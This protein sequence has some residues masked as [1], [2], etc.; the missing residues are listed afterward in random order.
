MPRSLQE[1]LAAAGEHNAAMGRGSR[2]GVSEDAMPEEPATKEGVAAGTGEDAGYLTKEETA[3]LPTN[4]R[5]TQIASEIQSVYGDEDSGAGVKKKR[6]RR[7]LSPLERATTATA[8]KYQ[9]KVTP[10]DKK[11]DKFN[12]DTP[13][14][15]RKL[16]VLETS[17]N[18]ANHILDHL[19][20]GSCADGE[21]K[22]NIASASAPT[23]T[24]GRRA[25]A[26]IDERGPAHDAWNA[27]HDAL[28]RFG[29]HFK[30]LPS[31]IRSKQSELQSR[32]PN[33]QA[34]LDDVN[35]RNGLTSDDYTH[36]S[37]QIESAKVSYRPMVNELTEQAK[38][39]SLSEKGTGSKVVGLQAD[40]DVLK[41]PDGKFR[42]NMDP[43]ALHLAIQK[44]ANNIYGLH[45][46]VK[47]TALHA[48]GLATPLSDAEVKGV[49]SLAHGLQSNIA[50]I[51]EGSLPRDV[52][53]TLK[54]TDAYGNIT[55]P[56]VALAPHGYIWSEQ[57][58]KS[59]KKVGGYVPPAILQVHPDTL[60]A[61]AVAGLEN[62]SE[63]RR[64]Q[65]LLKFHESQQ[66]G[67]K[68]R[69]YKLKN[70]FHNVDGTPFVQR[71]LEVPATPGTGAADIQARA[72]MTQEERDIA[73]ARVAED[74]VTL[75]T[76]V[77]LSSKYFAKGETYIPGGSGTIRPVNTVELQ[78]LERV[79]GTEHPD[80]ILMDNALRKNQGRPS[81]E[82][83]AAAPPKENYEG[84]AHSFGTENTGEGLLDLPLGPPRQT[85]Q[86]K[87]F[88]IKE[89]HDHIVMGTGTNVAYGGQI[90]A[91]L[92]K[93][94]GPGGIAAAMAMVKQ[95]KRRDPRAE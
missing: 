65:D 22:N 78:R 10:V 79:L 23:P 76:H 94:I 4:E 85:G 6:S 68:G 8:G 41:T 62:T 53:H 3:K 87:Q 2:E 13:D 40:L 89:A 64:M 39:A 28:M 61:Y 93:L 50:P 17:Q 49:T 9:L 82:E 34:M 14:A 80:T 35:S 25:S 21:C 29:N 75:G 74:G 33:A 44:V 66:P 51:P 31:L 67:Y 58:S 84:P 77:R 18:H 63:A 55:N 57:G 43:N 12:R 47:R 91:D 83:E 27:A 86:S 70:K 73:D 69:P 46:N 19:A 30:A 16:S 95:T 37:R 72:N 71:K 38:K 60:E 7:L 1:L 24:I 81:R 20:N 92:R 88:L 11:L 32:V 26:G 48:F 15:R 45:Q 90:P 59:A 54:E 42:P 52:N 36:V 56:E 5:I